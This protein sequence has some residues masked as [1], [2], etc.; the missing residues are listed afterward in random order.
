[1]VILT[2]LKT[3]EKY[4]SPTELAILYAALGDQEK[5]LL[6][7]KKPLPNATFN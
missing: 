4:V 3:T 6:H 2:K 1:M 5:R 7:S